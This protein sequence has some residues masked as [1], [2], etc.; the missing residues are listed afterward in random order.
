MS[1][2]ATK[3]KPEFLKENNKE[4]LD[5][6]QCPRCRYLLKD[7]VQ[8]SCGHWLCNDCAEHLFEAK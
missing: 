4:Q 7:A 6:Y 8:T 2:L 5:K 3:V 1:A